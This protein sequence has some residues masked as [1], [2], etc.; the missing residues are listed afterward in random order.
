M[1]EAYVTRLKNIR[2]HSNADRLQIAECFGNQV[3]VDLSYKEGDLGIYFPTDGKLGKEFAEI[4]DLIRRKDENGNDVGG[5][6]DPEKRNIKAI[7]LRGEKSDGLFLPLKSLEKF[8]NISELQVGDRITT[9][10]GTLIC[11]KYIPRTNKKNIT[12]TKKMNKKKKDIEFP[13]FAEHVDTEQLDYNLENFKKGDLCYI[14]LKM[15][16]T[17]QRTGNLPKKNNKNLITKL[18]DKYLK[19][20]Y[21]VITG[22][23]RVVLDKFSGNTGFYNDDAFRKK[24]HDLLKNK[25]YKGEE[26]YYEIVG[27]VNE[28]TPII[29]DGNNKKIQDKEFI[30]KYGDKTRFSYGCDVGINDIYVYR[31]TIT[32]EDGYVV[33]Y[34]WE[35]VKTRCEEME[36]NH[37]PELEK[38]FYTT[39]EDLKKRVDKY[40]DIADPVGKTHI[41]EGV[42]VRIDNKKNFKAYKKKGFFFKVLERYYKR[43]RRST[44][45]GGNTRMIKFYMMIGLPASGKSTIAK[46]IAKRENAIIIST[47][48]LRQEL[49]ND[50]NSQEN[51]NMIFEEA[52]KR[53]KANIENGKNVIFDATNIN[54]K[55]RRDWL[56]RFNKY[57][58]KKIGVLVAT[59]YEECL[60]RNKRRERKVPEEVIKRMYFNF[61]IPQYYEGFT[62]I[63]IK[64]NNGYI[65][66]FEDLQ[67]IPQDN[68]HHTL[69]VLKHCEKVQNILDKIQPQ[70]E[71]TALNRA[72]LLH[73]IGKLK[74][75]TFVNCKGEITD[76]AH[77]YNHERVS[78]YDSLFNFTIK[79]WYAVD[80]ISRILHTLNLIQWHML[81]HFDLSEK[82]ITKYK[83]MLGEDIWKELEILHKADCEGRQ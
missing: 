59:P 48:D 25:L 40:L 56:N 69:T 57:A 79:E 74:T 7:K 71:P 41:A 43:Y 28:N 11:E 39:E 64:Y 70:F 62:D 27:Y 75:K 30:K 81:L 13:L 16:G 82:T 58:V 54:Y 63:Q 47:D 72:G 2:K 5:Y 17:S 45:Y 31:M 26:I 65:F 67:D 23:R 76:I 51:N 83:N 77:F 34:P 3:V 32:N 50:V 35:L 12:T 60:E 42:V 38:F 36:I 10:N 44:R 66:T 21:D 37:V 53:L 29:P 24:Y 20:K 6:L 14:T 18:K 55:K 15:H 78:A 46:E 33:E 22:T 68:P 8:G 19:T 80:N 9:F 52:E 61:Y 73:D 49:L 1:Y 4:N